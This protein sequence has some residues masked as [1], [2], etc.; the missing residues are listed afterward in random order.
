MKTKRLEREILL[1]AFL[2]ILSLHLI[3]IMLLAAEKRVTIAAVGDCSFYRRLTPQTEESFLKLLELIR[4]ADVAYGNMEGTIHDKKGYPAPKDGGVYLM[5]EPFIADE[6]KWAGFDIM[7]LANNHSMDYLIEGLLATQKNLERTGMVYAGSGR[8]LEEASAPAYFDS[9][10]R[11]I[12]LVNCTSTFPSWS[13]ASATRGDMIGRP[14]I[15]PLRLETIYQVTKSDLEIL[16]RIGTDL[17]PP[18]S[19]RTP[20]IREIYNLLGIGRFKA[21][22]EGE[23]I[24]E[25]DERDV[26]RTIDAI[27]NARQSAHIVMVSVHAHSQ[28][29][30]LEKFARAC[31]DAGADVILGSGPH[32]LKGLEIYKGKPIF[33]SLGNILL[34]ND[35]Y[36]LLQIFRD[37]VFWTS[38]V[39]WIV[40]SDGKLEEIKLYPITLNYGAERADPLGRPFLADGDTGKKIIDQMISLST[41]YGTEIIYK[42]GIGVVQVK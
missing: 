22:P 20:P 19:G 32:L 30:Y 34:Q 33:Y 10:N 28:G 18:Q 21:G 17:R 36:D 4:K 39:A 35:L 27:K 25:A 40:F 2:L 11:R 13:L 15:N 8:N 23:V 12:A 1:R 9:K 7:G 29:P 38:V 5:F 37:E 14:G 26:K 42:E 3:G 24:V 16:K 6:L 41:P 31:I